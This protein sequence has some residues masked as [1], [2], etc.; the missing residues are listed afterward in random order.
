M[1]LYIASDHA[2]L[3]LK[4]ILKKYLLGQ[5]IICND[6]GTNSKNRVDYPDITLKLITNVLEKPENKGILIC[7]SG[8]GVTISANR[9]Q[10][11]RACLCHNGYTAKMAKAH[12]NCNVL[13]MGARVI[14]VDIAI[15][16]VDI[17]LKTQFEKGRHFTR[18][19]KIET[20]LK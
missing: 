5:K 4:E 10:N 16:I 6:V 7:G 17:W 9:F 11:I 8:L 13:T 1:N 3:E 2:G 14:G 20:N 19:N 18:I 15:D 12:N